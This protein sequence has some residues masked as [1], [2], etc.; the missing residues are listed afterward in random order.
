[1]IEAKTKFRFGN[2]VPK[3]WTLSISYSTPV[4]TVY[5][6]KYSLKQRWE[7]KFVRRYFCFVFM[8]AQIQELQNT[9]IQLCGHIIRHVEHHFL[10]HGAPYDWWCSVNYWVSSPFTFKIVMLLN[11]KS[12]FIVPVW[13]CNI[14]DQLKMKASGFKTKKT[15]SIGLLTRGYFYVTHKQSLLWEMNIYRNSN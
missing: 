3:Q 4:L 1:M 9:I 14:L 7:M 6:D 10:N 2:I 15:N 13:I 5:K 8:C 11:W 12:K